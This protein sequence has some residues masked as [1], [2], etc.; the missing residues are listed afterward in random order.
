MEPG[1]HRSSCCKSSSWLSRV[2]ARHATELFPQRPFLVA[3]LLGQ[4]HVDDRVEV[5]ALAAALTFGQTAP[6]HTKLLAVVRTG[7]DAHIHPAVE[8]GHARGR[9]E[10]GFPWREVQ[11]VIEIRAA[12]AK[13]G[14]RSQPHAEVEIAVRAAAGAFLAFARHADDLAF[15]HP[16]GNAD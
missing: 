13:I 1:S 2:E 15:L 7:W 10:H 14:M 8:C 3:E 6:T 16:G 11:I 4:L 9:S 12:H 5:A